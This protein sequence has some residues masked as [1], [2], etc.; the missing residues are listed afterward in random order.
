MLKNV[1]SELGVP[2]SKQTEE[3][4]LDIVFDALELAPG[5]FRREFLLRENFTVYM[6]RYPVYASMQQ[7]F[8]SPLVTR[9]HNNDLDCV[10]IVSDSVIKG[11]SSL[12]AGFCTDDR[13]SIMSLLDGLL[14]GLDVLIR[15]YKVSPDGGDSV[16]AAIFP[17]ES[18]LRF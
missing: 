3:E 5:P 13:Q 15:E 9:M 12:F 7:G 11:K 1:K 16:F 6:D 14:F 4:I 2:N 10:V 18:I 8:K 17:L